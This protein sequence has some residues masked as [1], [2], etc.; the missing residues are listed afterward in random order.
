ML[1][2]K[3][4]YSVKTKLGPVEIIDFFR[5]LSVNPKRFFIKIKF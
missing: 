1:G 3:T 4:V 2:D 5:E